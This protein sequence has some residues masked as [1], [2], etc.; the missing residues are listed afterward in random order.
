NS[1]GKVT[2]LVLLPGLMENLNSQ[3]GYQFDN[4]SP[5]KIFTAGG[6]QYAEVDLFLEN[7]D[8]VMAV[9][10]KTVATKDEVIKHVSRIVRL[11]EHETKAGLTGK[12]IYAAMAGITFDADARE[13]A[14]ASGMYLV[15]LDHSNALITIEPPAGAVGKW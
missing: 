3:F 8:A 15:E 5:N 10:A 9:E 12:T 7:G 4:I 13:L 11:R 6:K 2:E 1:L 14:R